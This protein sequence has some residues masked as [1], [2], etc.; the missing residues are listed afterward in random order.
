MKL[1]LKS[2][3]MLVISVITMGCAALFAAAAWQT[4]HKLSEHDLR[5]QGRMAAELMRMTIT[6][7]MF[8]GNPSHIK[9]YLARLSEIPG[10]QDAYV[11]PATSVQKQ[12]NISSS[13]RRTP[14]ANEATVFS[15]GQPNGEY[16]ST[17]RHIF[18]YSI[19]YT[20]KANGTPNCLQCHQAK[21]GEVLGIV[22]FSMDVT[23]QQTVAIWAITGI[24]VLSL[25]F[26]VVI[27]FALKRLLHPIVT[28]TEALSVVIQHAEAGD[29]SKRLIK[30][31]DDEIG[32]IT[33]KTNQLMQ[34]LE[35]SF[36]NMAKQVED[37]TG[38]CHDSHDGGLLT[39]TVR[40]V[41]SMTSAS[42]F[43][44]LIEN[45]R[46][47]TDVYQRILR[48]LPRQFGIS[49]FSLYEV[50]NSKNHLTL[51]TAEGMPAPAEMWCEREVLVDADACRAKRTAQIISS[52][53]EDLICGTFCGNKIQN[54][55]KLLHRCI[56]IMLSGSVGGVLQVVYTPEETDAVRENIFTLQSY[57]AEAAPVIEAKRL[58]QSLKDA[59]MHDPM[60]GLYNRRF[61]DG[62]LETLLATV[63]RQ[64]ITVGILMCDVDF[65]KQ[66]NDTYGHEVGD[67]VLI[68]VADILKNAVRTSDLVI[69]FGGEEFIALLVGADEEVSLRVAERIRLAMAA[70]AFQTSNGPLKKTIS[71]GVSLF[72]V[73]SDGFWN[74]LKFADVALY[75][76]KETG[77]NKVLR[78]SKEMWKEGDDNY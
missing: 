29:F 58:M 33:E 57:L 66:V 8:E 42:N 76:A 64:K 54:D 14:T 69:R 65:F 73:D 11:I 49:R 72:P 1:Q 35:N 15:S 60:T 70:C 40:A 22:S 30:H 9:P 68:K 31:S 23:T 34:I 46:N 48:V 50:A 5:L 52:H 63:Q 38:T 19:P 6:H 59:S 4:L 37:L 78:F 26:G 56:P 12:M 47:L 2:K 43:K 44:Q 75:Q 21:E 10:L 32:A 7:E 61:L 77:R 67:K 36:G 25:V 71:V 20:A 17:N 45:D 24:G 41:N 51:V 53:N 3:M 16:V 62:Y 28:T 13:E 74:C 55:Q 39:R 27:T 18:R